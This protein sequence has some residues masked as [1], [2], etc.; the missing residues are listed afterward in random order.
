MNID[1]LNAAN[2]YATGLK[3]VENRRAQWLEK[4]KA[5]HGHL[6]EI[7]TMLNEKAEYKQGFFVDTSFA[8][9]EEI[10]GTCSKIPSVTFRSGSM[11]MNVSFKSATAGKL[12]YTEEGFHL[13]FMPTITGQVLVLLR[14]HTSNLDTE[15]PEEV[16]MAVIDNP[17]VLSLNDVSLIVLKAIK[18][19]F[20]TSFTGMVELQEEQLQKA[21]P[22][23]HTPIG[24][25]R[26]DS[27]EKVI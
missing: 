26:H 10:N 11:P 6:K 20:Y 15:K 22:P 7:A 2:Q 16:N 27:T 17:S 8:Y 25:K 21:Q 4:Y 19:A 9:N 1:I 14:P 13:T 5:I 18:M 24:F 3:E 23:K 12:D